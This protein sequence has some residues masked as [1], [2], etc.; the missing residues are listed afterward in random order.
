MFWGGIKPGPKESFNKPGGT[1]KEKRVQ[2]I[3]NPTGTP[4]SNSKKGKGLR[5]RV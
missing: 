5:G 2:R 4:S 3:I 1:G